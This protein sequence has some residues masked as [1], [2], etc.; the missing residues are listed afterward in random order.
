MYPDELPEER[1]VRLD[2][3]R[4]ASPRL[5]L[6]VEAP[7]T[8]GLLYGASHSVQPE[9]FRSI[10]G[11]LDSATASA[12]ETLRYRA[13]APGL[14]VTP[15]FHAW[16]DG[17]T[18]LPRLHVHL[19]T[20]PD[21]RQRPLISEWALMVQVGYIAALQRELKPAGIRFAAADTI[22]QHEVPGLVAEL[23]RFSPREPCGLGGM[24]QLAP[25]AELERSWRLRQSAKAS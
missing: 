8:L 16:A 9:L 24:E 10:E 17:V 19:V 4:L 23:E 2:R 3:E 1:R 21:Q 13:E 14:D 15:V 7:L 20:H 18:D 5:D 25:V 12:I 6:L 11:A 22:V